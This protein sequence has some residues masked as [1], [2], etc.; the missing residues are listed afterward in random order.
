MV[1]RKTVRTRLIINVGSVRVCSVKTATVENGFD[2]KKCLQWAHTVYA[3][4]P[5][6]AFV[7][8]GVGNVSH[9]FIAAAKY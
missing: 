7:S 4:Y 5:K 8:G 3:D 1:G 9:F 2:A 6:R